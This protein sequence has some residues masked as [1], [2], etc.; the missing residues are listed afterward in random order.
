[1][2]IVFL[3]IILLQI[4]CIFSAHIEMH[5]K[6]PAKEFMDYQRRVKGIPNDM[7]INQ[8]TVKNFFF[9]FFFKIIIFLILMIRMVP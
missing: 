1:M 2:K 6:R 8:K 9:F 4:Y 5:R 7:R 3:L